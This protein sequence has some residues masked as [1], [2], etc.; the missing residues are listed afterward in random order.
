MYSSVRCGII[1]YFNNIVHSNDIILDYI[2]YEFDGQII[3]ESRLDGAAEKFIGLHILE[4]ADAN[5]N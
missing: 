5:S 3:T 2:I 1:A 4:F